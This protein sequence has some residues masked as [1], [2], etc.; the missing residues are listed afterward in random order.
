MT[1]ADQTHRVNLMRS[2]LAVKRHIRQA[3]LFQMICRRPCASGTV[4]G[5][6]VERKACPE[7]RSDLHRDCFGY[8]PVVVAESVAIMGIERKGSDQLIS[9]E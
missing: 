2:R 3:G 1:N 9:V 4:T 6:T 5:G 7:R 8:T